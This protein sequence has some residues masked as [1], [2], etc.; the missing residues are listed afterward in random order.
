MIFFPSVFTI[1]DNQC[2]WAIIMQQYMHLYFSLDSTEEE[3][4]KKKKLRSKLRRNAIKLSA[5]FRCFCFIH[6]VGTCIESVFNVFVTYIVSVVAIQKQTLLWKCER[7][8]WI[9][10]KFFIDVGVRIQWIHPCKICTNFKWATSLDSLTVTELKLFKNFD[11]VLHILFIHIN[12][13]H[14][15]I[16]FKWRW[17]EVIFL[18]YHSTTFYSTKRER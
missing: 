3:E 5:T 11:I 9:E 7:K 17:I 6:S 12:C 10:W 4:S 15:Y 16:H 13:T 2:I 1:N 18:V 14:M 8:K